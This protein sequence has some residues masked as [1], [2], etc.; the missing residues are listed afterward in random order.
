LFVKLTHLDVLSFM[1]YTWDKHFKALVHLPNLTHLSIGSAIETGVILQLLLHCCLL[2][3]LLI[4]PD[5]P[6]PYLA[7][8]DTLERLAKIND[9][10]LVVLV[11]PPFPGLV[12]D[13]EK[14]ARGGI[15]CWAFSELV[16]FAQ[17]RALFY[18]LFHEFGMTHSTLICNRELL[19]RPATSVF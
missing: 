8:G 18:S 5:Y 12:H 11:S 16:S 19:C 7:K 13:W 3:I 4:S 10:R 15:D 17:R 6:Y 1:G 2:Q 14:G 9:Y